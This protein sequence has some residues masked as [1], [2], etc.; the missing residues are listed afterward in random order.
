MKTVE[1]TGRP[2]STWT[3]LVTDDP[4]QNQIGMMLTGPGRRS[5]IALYSA[6]VVMPLLMAWG[7]VDR[8]FRKRPGRRGDPFRTG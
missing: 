1:T 6:V 3:C 5:T 2:S 8:V 4:F 7:I